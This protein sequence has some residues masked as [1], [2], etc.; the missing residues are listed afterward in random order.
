MAEAAAEVGRRREAVVE[1]VLDTTTDTIVAIS[2]R[3]LATTM[4]TM[5]KKIALT[6]MK[7]SNS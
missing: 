1:A 7:Q 5:I 2:I 4:M 3:I 6:I